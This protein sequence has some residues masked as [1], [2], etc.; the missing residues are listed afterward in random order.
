VLGKLYSVCASLLVLVSAA[1]AA[2]AMLTNGPTTHRY[3]HARLSQLRTRWYY[4][5]EDLPEKLMAE[6]PLGRPLRGEVFLSGERDDNDVQSIL[7]KALVLGDGGDP[8]AAAAAVAA[9]SHTFILR[10]HFNPGT[11]KFEV[12]AAG[13][14]SPLQAAA[15]T[16]VAPYQQQQ[17]QQQQYQQHQQQQQQ[18]R[19]SMRLDEF[20]ATASY[21]QRQAPL[22]QQ[23]R[24]QHLQ[25]DSAGMGSSRGS[26]NSTSALQQLQSTALQQQPRYALEKRD[27]QLRMTPVHPQHQHQ[28]QQQQQLELPSRQQQHFNQYL[29][30]HQQQQHYQQQQMQAQ[31]AAQQLQL[32]QLQRHAFYNSP[33]A[34][35]SR[36]LPQQQTQQQ[37]QQQSRQQRQNY[38]SNSG[39]SAA[40][41]AA[42][43]PWTALSGAAAIAERLQAVA[44]Q[45]ADRVTGSG[46]PVNT[47]PRK[48]AASS[49]SSSSAAPAPAAGAFRLGSAAALAAATAAAEAASSAEALN[50][51]SEE[52]GAKRE[53]TAAAVVAAQ[54]PHYRDSSSTASP[55]LNDDSSSRAQR[56][57]SGTAAAAAA[58]T[59][60]NVGGIGAANPPSAGS[61]ASPGIQWVLYTYPG[62]LTS[63]EGDVRRASFLQSMRQWYSMWTVRPDVVLRPWRAQ[64]D[65]K[66][67]TAEYWQ[68]YKKASHFSVCA[69]HFSVRATVL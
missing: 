42:A 52:A 4:R 15:G 50:Q 14:Q 16:A 24:Q 63:M 32:Q 27:L 30:E 40:A 57:G 54:F 43:T 61:A 37:A 3:F 21:M 2:T 12:L 65:E 22:Q 45:S 60:T 7:G 62:L 34:Q 44:A 23:Q 5:P 35:S 59:V 68:D 6:Y 56:R 18:D 17:Q 26:S 58:G 66:N 49:T 29:S 64:P 19:G 31:Q 47:K 11:G 55:A 33:A 20:A 9:N 53:D 13:K 28:Q 10:C 25:S 69:S 48:Y 67:P 36:A 51:W 38:S 1:A 41:A 8:Q 46:S 39:N